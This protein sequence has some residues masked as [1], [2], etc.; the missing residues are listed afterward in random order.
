MLGKGPTKMAITGGEGGSPNHTLIAVLFF[1]FNIVSYIARKLGQACRPITPM[2][3]VSSHHRNQV[4]VVYPGQG[5]DSS[6]NSTV[7]D[8]H[9]STVH[10]TLGQD[11][12]LCHYFII[13][14]ANAGNMFSG[15]LRCRQVRN[16]IQKMFLKL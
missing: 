13:S 7:A 15:S 8:T 3:Q 10:C 6:P 9:Q 16:P 5:Y 14:L 4:N 12:T 2:K 1:V 11:V